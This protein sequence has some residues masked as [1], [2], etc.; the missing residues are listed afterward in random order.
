MKKRERA[1]KYC[2]VSMYLYDFWYH[3][4]NSQD[5]RS[6]TKI[7]PKIVNILS[8]KLKMPAISLLSQTGLPVLNLHINFIR[9]LGDST[10]II[11]L[12]ETL[13]IIEQW[14]L[15]EETWNW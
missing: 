7:D 2:P 15:W 4:L 14:S 11:G 5:I 12:I 10:I 8:T 1:L 9:V 6:F 3:F 13:S